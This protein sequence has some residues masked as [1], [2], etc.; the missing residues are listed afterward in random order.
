MKHLQSYPDVEKYYQDHPDA[1]P[2]P[3]SDYG[4][5]WRDDDGGVWRVTYVH[6]TGHVYAIRSSSTGANSERV[7]VGG[8][9]AVLVS[10]GR[11]AG[12][13]VI[14]GK[15]EPWEDSDDP[16][17]WSPPEPAERALEG[18]AEVCGS[19]GSLAWVLERVG[20]AS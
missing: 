20:G 6:T 7:N 1:R 4:V 14:L 10:A 9:V 17:D 5:W 11:E 16:G 19:Q 15:L 13:V 2:S 8:Q 12:P 18:W 3:E